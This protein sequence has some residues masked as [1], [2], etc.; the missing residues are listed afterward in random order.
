MKKIAIAAVAAMSLAGA[1]APSAEAYEG[2]C[3]KQQK[4]FDKYNVEIR[5]DSP[6]LSYAYNEACDVTG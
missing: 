3:A 6:V 4:L 5:I 2:P 1:T